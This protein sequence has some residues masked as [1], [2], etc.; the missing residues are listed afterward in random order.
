[1]TGA[2]ILQEPTVTMRMQ[3]RQKNDAQWDHAFL[4]SV[5][6]FPLTQACCS[7]P[8]VELS[9]DLAVGLCLDIASNL[10]AFLFLFIYF[11]FV[12]NS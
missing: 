3:V 11:I 2:L 5:L 8:Q 1:M 7:I 10:T 9:S 6:M 12:T 4:K